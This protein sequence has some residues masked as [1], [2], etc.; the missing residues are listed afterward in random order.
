MEFCISAHKSLAK[1][2]QLNKK[3]EKLVSPDQCNDDGERN[4]IGFNSQFYWLKL[5]QMSLV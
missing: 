4:E 1:P 3:P 5:S 2:E